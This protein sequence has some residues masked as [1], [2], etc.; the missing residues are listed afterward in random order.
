MLRHLTFGF[1]STLPTHDYDA[2]AERYL[3]RQR[4][5]FG[6]ETNCLPDRREYTCYDQQFEQHYPD[7]H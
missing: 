1:S 7:Y 2:K 5:L 4:F 3:Q 6:Q